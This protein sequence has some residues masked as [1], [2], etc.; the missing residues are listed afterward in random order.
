MR[1]LEN[2]SQTRAQGLEKDTFARFAHTSVLLDAADADDAAD[3]A[4]ADE[5]RVVLFGCACPLCLPLSFALHAPGRQHAQA[6]LP[7]HL[8]QA[9]LSQHLVQ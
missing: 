8:V 1:H 3:A 4:D 5:C 2:S 7:E 9:P 6:P